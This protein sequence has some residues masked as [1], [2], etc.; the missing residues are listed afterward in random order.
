[1]LHGLPASISAS[2]GYAYEYYLL[3]GIM[4][5]GFLMLLRPHPAA[6]ITLAVVVTAALA[7][8]LQ[9]AMA[10]LFA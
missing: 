6:A 5:V 1:L 2:A 3:H 4:L 7:V 9:R 10:R 8:L